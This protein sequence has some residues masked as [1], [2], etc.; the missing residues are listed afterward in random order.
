[1]K[2][3]L[4]FD[5][6]EEKFSNFKLPDWHKEATLTL[7]GGV[8]D[9]KYG[10]YLY[11]FIIN[12]NIKSV[13]DIGTARGYSAVCIAKALKEIGGGTV[14]SIDVISADKKKNWHCDKHLNSDPAKDKKLSIKDFV[15]NFVNLNDEDIEINFLKGDSIKILSDWKH[16][17]YDLIFHDGAHSYEKVKDEILLSRRN[18]KENLIHVFDDANPLG[19][20]SEWKTC[21]DLNLVSDFINLPLL[22][23]L[24]SFIVRKEQYP[25]ISLVIEESFKE[26]GFSKMEIVKDESHFPITMIK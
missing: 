14:Y 6:L 20:A 23:K 13:V 18:Q 8:D 2:K 11:N 17:D 15:G 4:F 9:G 16:K 12:N 21:R 24:H 26:G 22:R 3:T 5:S 7:R 10:L 25:G 19:F 1:M